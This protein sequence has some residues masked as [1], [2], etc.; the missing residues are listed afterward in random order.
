MICEKCG[1]NVSTSMKCSL[2]GHD[3]KS[4]D[5][6]AKDILTILTKTKS[7]GLVTFCLFIA[8]INDIV[9][10]VSNVFMYRKDIITPL[11]FVIFTMITVFEITLCIFMLKL[12]KWAYNTYAF[13]SLIM[14]VC[15]SLIYGPLVLVHRLIIMLIILL[16]D[17]KNLK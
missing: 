7:R 13:I 17:R 10:L 5:Y 8:L 1:G 6:E 3:N 16:S 15:V 14:C 11:A 4:S 2:C 12:K 9:L